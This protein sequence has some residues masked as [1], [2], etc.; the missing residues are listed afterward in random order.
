M[1]G[2]LK[3]KL[4]AQL[5]GAGASGSE[6]RVLSRAVR[7]LAPTAETPI[8]GKTATARVREN[9]FIENVEEFGAELSRKPFFYRPVLE[10]GKIPIAEAIVAEKI[11]GGCSKRA[12]RRGD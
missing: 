12:G 5:N 9:R 8:T 6:Q 10:Q 2:D 3:D 4:Q 11:P 7:R 1:S